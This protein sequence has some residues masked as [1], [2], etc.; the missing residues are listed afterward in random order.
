[1]ARRLLAALLAGGASVFAFAPFDLFPLAFLGLGALAWLLGGVAR[2][3]EG[4]ALGFAWGFGAFIGGVSW[5]YVALER[6]GGMPAPLAGL[7]IA[8]F[9]AYLALYPGLVGAAFIGLRRRIGA[10][11]APPGGA[12]GCTVGAGLPAIAATERATFAG[13]P[14]PTGCVPG[15]SASACGAGADRGSRGSSVG[16]VIADRSS[17]AHRPRVRTG[18]SR[19]RRCTGRR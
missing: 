11:S 2:W 9:C 12:G 13:E 16:A 18:A 14:A 19:R 7:A 4:F 17:A 15:A 3:R 5:L 8:L 6:Y 10:R 1:M